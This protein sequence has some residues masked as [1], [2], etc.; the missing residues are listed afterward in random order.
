M[1]IILLVEQT[2]SIIDYGLELNSSAIILDDI[3][4][5]DRSQAT[6]VFSTQGRI[7]TEN[8]IMIHNFDTSVEKWLHTL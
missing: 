1:H 5:R 6:V 4:V 7:D 2:L 3:A 8:T